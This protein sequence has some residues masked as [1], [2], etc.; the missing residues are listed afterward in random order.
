M[1]ILSGWCSLIIPTIQIA[2]TREVY[3]VI[4]YDT[5]ETE[6]HTLWSS[7][8][9]NI[10]SDFRKNWYFLPNILHCPGVDVRHHAVDILPHPGPAST[11]LDAGRFA[12]RQES[13]LDTQCTD[14]ISFNKL[15]SGGECQDYQAVV[16][17]LF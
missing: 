4:K 9:A 10:M 12:D 14:F 7:R 6:N 11:S 16:L 8:D 5:H 2:K 13:R 17:K 3:I 15:N 1:E